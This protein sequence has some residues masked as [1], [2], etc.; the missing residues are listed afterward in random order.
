MSSIHTARQ[1][2]RS[3]KTAIAL[4]N[5]RV[6][7]DLAAGLDG[8]KIV[9][10]AAEPSRVIL[11][12]AP[13]PDD[14]VLGC[15]GA[16]ALHGTKHDTVHVVYLGD[17]A[18]GNSSGKRDE[19]LIARRKKEAVTGMH[20]LAKATLHFLDVP[21]GTLAPTPKTVDRVRK[22][23]ELIQPDRIYVPWFGDDNP[24]HAQTFLVAKQALGNIKTV[25]PIELWQY[26]LWSPLVPNRIVPIAK[27][28]AKKRAAMREHR[29]QLTDRNYLAAIEGLNRYR[30]EIAKID[31]AAEAFFTG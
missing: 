1:L 6:L 13:H 19:T 5:W 16:L 11:V 30:G 23:I 2:A 28:M 4:T 3:V 21:D 15:G 9:D 10:I 12:C 31:G 24:D 25:G 18:R 14:E 7:K 20:H 26:E 29:S 27:V 8:L 17:G 22:L